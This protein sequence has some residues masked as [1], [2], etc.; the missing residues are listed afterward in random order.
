MW[1]ISVSYDIEPFLAKKM[2]NC[3]GK[4]KMFSIVLEQCRQ[5]L[6][7]AYK[8]LFLSYLLLPNLCF[9]WDMIIHL[10]VPHGKLAQK[11]SSLPQTLKIKL[12]AELIWIIIKLYIEEEIIR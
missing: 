1:K 8:Y 7:H 2:L 6:R 11:K 12:S 5:D 4:E 3:M 10:Q 9:I